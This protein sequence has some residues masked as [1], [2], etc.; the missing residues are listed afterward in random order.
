MQS[1]RRT[2]SHRAF[3]CIL[4]LCICCFYKSHVWD[5]FETKRFGVRSASN[6]L[7]KSSTFMRKFCFKRHRTLKLVYL[8]LDTFRFFEND[9]RASTDEIWLTVFWRMFS[10]NRHPGKLHSSYFFFTREVGTV[11]F[12][13]NPLPVANWQNLWRFWELLSA[14]T[15]TFLQKL[16]VEWQQLLR[17]PQKTL[18]EVFI[19]FP[20]TAQNLKTPYLCSS[21][22]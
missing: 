15:P 19:T 11:I 17:F 7:S 12:I 8:T 21:Q 1:V 22:S 14:I 13:K 16:V 6:Y 10:K 5:V 9:Y 20:N 3:A 4:I 18:L 2:Y